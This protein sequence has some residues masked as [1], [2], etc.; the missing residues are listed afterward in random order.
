M[1]ALGFPPREAFEATLEEC[2][3]HGVKLLI[4]DSLG[5]ALE[6][7]AEAARDVIGFYQK[8][9]EPFRTAGVTV[10]VVDHQSRLQAGERYQ[11]KR[12]FGSVFKTNLARS[13][14][15]VEAV[16]RGE[17]M[18]VV[19][20]RQNKHNFGALTN[21]LGAKLSFSEEQVTIDAVELEE[22][23]LT[24]EETLSAR[25]RVLMALRM[26]GEGT[27]SEVAEL[28]TGLT[29]GTVKKE[30]SKLRKGGAV[31]ETGEVRD[32]ARVVRCVTVTDTYR[33][34]GN[35]NAPESASPAAKGKFG[36]RI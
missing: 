13:V 3:A 22:E 34:N 15:Q 6:G 20:L 24:T 29:L 23:D 10:L 25:D 7:D 19:R 1:S 27:P 12:A 14:V 26:V 11:N 5:P 4:L 33:G 30:L 31:E 35:G 32:R 8:V 16:E 36:G 21:P 18:L 9:L 28:T 2:K 17:N